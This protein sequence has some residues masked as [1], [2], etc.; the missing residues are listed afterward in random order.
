MECIPLEMVSQ[1]S[2]NTF[3]PIF[4]TF[5]RKMESIFP[6]VSG[7]VCD[8]T[9]VI[10]MMLIT[11]KLSSLNNH[12]S[13]LEPYSKFLSQSIQRSP[14]SYTQ[15]LEL[16]HNSGR[17]FSKDRDRYYLTRTIV[18][19]LIS[20]IRFKTFVPDENLMMLVQFVLQDLD[21]TLVYSVVTEHLKPNSDPSIE[22][23][24]TNACEFIKPYVNDINEFITDVHTLSRIKVINH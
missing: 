21:G 9:P 5:L 1:Q 24:N 18:A 11:L 16:C 20:A 3:L 4:D 22:H 10:R 23:Y 19:E 13:I 14:L 8:L 7:E 15:L 6:S 2:W 12:R 17:V